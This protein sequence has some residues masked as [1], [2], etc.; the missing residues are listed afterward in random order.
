MLKELNL[1][2]VYLSPLALHLAIAAIAWLILRWML[3]KTGAYRHV[4]HAPLF[5]TALYVILLA[6]TFHHLH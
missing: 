3:Q 5:N 2:G 4:W 6:A 1:F